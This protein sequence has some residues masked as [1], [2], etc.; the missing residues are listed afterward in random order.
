MCAFF[1]ETTVSCK[2]KLKFEMLNVPD[3]ILLQYDD[4]RDDRCKSKK[5][6]RRRARDS[7]GFSDKHPSQRRSTVF[8]KD[9]VLQ[10]DSGASPAMKPP[11]QGHSVT[12]VDSPLRERPGNDTNS[13]YRPS[14]VGNIII[15]IIR[16][17]VCC[18]RRRSWPPPPHIPRPQFCC[19][20]S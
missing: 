15:I 1:Q 4:A 2:H 5:R 17:R 16:F 9:G 6:E 12:S 3:G 14:Q 13:R 19:V 18:S 8:D 7:G 20:L 11:S 10:R